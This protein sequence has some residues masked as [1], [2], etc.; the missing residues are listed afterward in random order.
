MRT[1]RIPEPRFKEELKARIAKRN[2]TG[3]LGKVRMA[4]FSRNKIGVDSDIRFDTYTSDPC[5]S[6][7][8]VCS[9][10]HL[11]RRMVSN[12]VVVYEMLR[13]L[14]FT[15]KRNV[16]VFDCFRRLCSWGYLGTLQRF[17]TK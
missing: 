15:R 12:Y 2:E 6:V 14:K 1:A 10:Y 16:H 9:G 4:R 3:E 13:H 17:E 7:A 8:T 5:R 11:P